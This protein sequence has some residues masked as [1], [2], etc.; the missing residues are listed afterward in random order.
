MASVFEK[1]NK[2]FC[3][4]PINQTQTC[5]LS[6]QTKQP[7]CGW[8]EKVEQG[9]AYQQRLLNITNELWKDTSTTTVCSLGFSFRIKSRC[10][11]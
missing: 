3:D 9:N 2:Y 4:E 10:F 8:W 1:H 6:V 5:A 7:K 11:G